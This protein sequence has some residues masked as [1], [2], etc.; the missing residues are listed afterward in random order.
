MLI[1]PAG[2]AD[3]C[4]S[5]Y[6]RVARGLLCAA[7]N[8]PGRKRR[9]GSRSGNGEATFLNIVTWLVIGGVV[10][11]VASIIVR[12]DS[13]QGVF[14]NVVVGSTGSVVAGWFLSPLFGAPAIGDN[15][16]SMP[17]LLVSLLGAVILLTMANLLRRGAV[18]WLAS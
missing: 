13:P 3:V 1:I 10:G 9:V 4:A 16:F 6:V 11:W 12:T 18:R 14:L 2:R 5:A 17:V 15:I 8:R 7:A